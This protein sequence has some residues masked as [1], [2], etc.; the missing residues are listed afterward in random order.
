MNLILREGI[1]L[2]D[3]GCWRPHGVAPR[4]IHEGWFKTES[5]G[6][7]HTMTLLTNSRPAVLDHPYGSNRGY[8]HHSLL[9]LLRIEAVN[10]GLNHPWGDQSRGLSKGAEGPKGCPRGWSPKGDS[11]HIPEFD[12]RQ[13]HC[14]PIQDQQCWIIPTGAIVDIIITPC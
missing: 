3:T 2:G 13:W 12:S 6:R 14:P 10:N 5:Q 7:L 4:L 9:V 1:N 11:R 8:N